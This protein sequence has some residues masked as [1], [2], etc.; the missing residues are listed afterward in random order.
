VGERKGPGS[1]P[2]ERL[3]QETRPFVGGDADTE[4][5]IAHEYFHGF[6]LM[7]AKNSIRCKK[8]VTVA[9]VALEVQ[10]AFAH[11]GDGDWASQVSDR[12]QKTCA[13]LFEERLDAPEDA[14]HAKR[15]GSVASNPSAAASRNPELT[16]AYAANRFA[17]ALNCTLQ[18]ALEPGIPRVKVRAANAE[19]SPWTGGPINQAFL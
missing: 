1:K 18:A 13:R 4:L 6:E 17:L 5:D 19:V 3:F 11:D 15:T 10:R 9:R 7:M 12:L 14:G 8:G 2:L 16:C